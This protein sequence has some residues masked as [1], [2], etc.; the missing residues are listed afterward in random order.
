MVLWFGR[1]GLVLE[2][3]VVEEKRFFMF[4]WNGGLPLFGIE[5][6]LNIYLHNLSIISLNLFIIYI[7]NIKPSFTLKSTQFHCIHVSVV[8][9]ELRWTLVVPWSWF[10]HLLSCR[11]VKVRPS[12]WYREFCLCSSLILRIRVLSN[13]RNLHFLS[14]LPNSWYFVVLILFLCLPL[15]SNLLFLEVP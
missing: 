9:P 12:F 5:F 13:S 3:G 10:V 1:F 7:I 6:K 2:L 4:L 11:I 15:E 14:V 8:L